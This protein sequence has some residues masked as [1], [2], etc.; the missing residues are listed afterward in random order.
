MLGRQG[1][2]C[3]NG[4]SLFTA[5]V[6]SGRQVDPFFPCYIWAVF[7]PWKH[8]C[9]SI[10][11]LI[12]DLNGSK[13]SLHLNTQIHQIF[14]VGP[15]TQRTEECLVPGRSALGQDSESRRGLSLAR[16]NRTLSPAMRAS[17]FSSIKGETVG[18]TSQDD[19]EGQ[20]YN[21]SEGLSTQQE[22]GV[23]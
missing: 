16:G 3:H 22:H 14:R 6:G 12:L 11:A 5:E 13:N 18:C 20:R 2:T 1:L 4:F 15:G 8:Y 9:K 17:V 21:A 10:G 23:Y 7:C 19:W